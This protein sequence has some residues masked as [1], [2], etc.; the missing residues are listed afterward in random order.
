[1]KNQLQG[2]SNQG[3]YQISTF[4]QISNI[5]KRIQEIKS[6]IFESG[7]S[8]MSGTDLLPPDLQ[9]SVGSYCAFIVTNLKGLVVHV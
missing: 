6:Q 7:Y 1:M 9:H 2:D 5:S 4:I 8:W 3:I